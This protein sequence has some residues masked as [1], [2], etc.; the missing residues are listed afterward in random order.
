MVL[1]EVQKITLCFKKMDWVASTNYIRENFVISKYLSMLS[2]AIFWFKCTNTKSRNVFCG[3]ACGSICS[4]AMEMQID[5]LTIFFYFYFL[6]FR[7]FY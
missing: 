6:S 3:S 5:Y 2:D 4:T 7:S 1:Y